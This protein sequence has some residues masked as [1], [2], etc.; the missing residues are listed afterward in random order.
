MTV[1]VGATTPRDSAV[2]GVPVFATGAVPRQVGLSRARLADL[3]FEAKPGQLLLLPAASGPT[4]IAVGLGPREHVSSRSLRDAAAGLARAAGG[5]T[6]VATALADVDVPGL[7]REAVAQAVAEGFGLGTYQFTEFKSAPTPSRLERVVLTASSEGRAAVE[8]GA[9]RGQA[10]AEA[11]SLARDLANTPPADLNA[12][13]LA[14]RAMVIAA[15]HK[16]DIE[17]LDELAMAELGLGGMLGVNRGS[18]APPRLIKLTYAPRKPAATVALVGKGVMYD[19]GGI[20]LKPSDGMH[21]LMKMDMTGAAVVLATLSLLP[22]LKPNVKVIGFL[23]CTDNMPSG[24]AMKLGDVLRIRN[25]KTVEVHNTDAEGRLVL[26]DGLSLAVEDG[27]DAVVDIATLTG[28]VLGALG[29]K[30]A[31]VM[32]NDQSWVDQV[33]AAAD[34]TGERVWQLPLV[35]DYRKL[36]DSN[37]ADL[38]NVGGPY[39]GA[40]IAALFLRE[41]VGDVPWAHLDIAG[42]MDSDADD[43]IFSKGA[44]AFGVRLLA[45]LLTHYEPVQA[46]SGVEAA[47]GA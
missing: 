31:G 32:G 23:C 35:E 39:G 5:R 44:T 41:F 19:S 47:V 2:V 18:V 14:E 40:I 15:E 17:V 30:V 9:R 28:A 24:S 1:E 43:G 25:G 36:L 7:S 10:I 46:G 22:V 34:R 4:V 20:S 13:D 45:D 6:S 12:I 21:A 11:V 3:G 26:A 33:R 29:K 37:V 42:V 16:L 27:A 8:R 38:K